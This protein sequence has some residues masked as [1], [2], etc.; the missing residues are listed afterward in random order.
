MK[1]K[2]GYKRFIYFSSMLLVLCM[3]SGCGKEQEK[4][5]EEINQDDVSVTESEASGETAA[6]GQT[7]QDADTETEAA[8]ETESENMGE[9][10]DGIR[11]EIGRVSKRQYKNTSNVLILNSTTREIQVRIPGNQEA[12]DKINL[13]FADRKA[14]YEDTVEEYRDM[15]VSDLEMRTEEGLTEGWAGYEL[16]LDYEVKRA[17][18]RMI[19]IV[20]NGYEYT[21]G[22]HPNAMRVAYNFNAQT[23]ERMTLADVASDLDEIRMKSMAYLGELLEEPEWSELLFSDYRNHLEDIL[24]DSTWYTDQEGFHII[25][26]EYIITP[27][28]AGILEF[29]LP[30]DEVDVVA[31]QFQ[32]DGVRDDQSESLQ[33][34]GD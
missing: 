32:P 7:D 34:N 13:F 8:Q 3:L 29:L 17:D 25:C 12:E 24:T 6:D 2:N 15:A 18:E 16:G 27:H 31:E 30:Y 14:A 33:S 19:S 10:P 20:E 5:E 22:A 1:K 11:A 9:T 21:G 28:S 4:T 23:G 26:N